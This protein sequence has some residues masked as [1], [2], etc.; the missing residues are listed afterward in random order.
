MRLFY[1]PEYTLKIFFQTST[2]RSSIDL[3][4]ATKKTNKQNINDFSWTHQRIDISGQTTTPKSRK[5]VQS[6]ESPPR[7]RVAITGAIN[8]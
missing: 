6:T 8:L 5:T 1:G 3:I 2:F 4:L 7:S